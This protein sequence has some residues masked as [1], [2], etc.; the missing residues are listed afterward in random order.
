MESWV[1]RQYRKEDRSAI[2]RIAWETA[3]LGEPADIF[4]ENKEIVADFLT[5]YFTDYEPQ[6]CFVAEKEGR[7]VGYVFGTQNI[8]VLRRAF[9]IKVFPRLLIKF[10]GNKNML[11]KKNLLFFFNSLLSFLKGEFKMPDL[12]RDYPAVLHINIEKHFRNL[13]LG[14]RLI[15]TYLNYLAENRISG[16]HLA[17]LSERA[18]HFFKKQG[19]DLLFKGSRSYFKHILHKDIP[20]YIYGKRLNKSGDQGGANI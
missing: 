1:I 11:R 16:V 20:I 19:F 12:F 7:V 9:G 10:I 3:F 13:G 8:A 2:R 15:D 4:F 14:S 6:S 17:T 5:K 18:S